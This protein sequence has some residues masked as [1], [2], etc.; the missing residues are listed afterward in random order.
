MGAA[1]SVRIYRVAWITIRLLAQLGYEMLAQAT[2]KHL[3]RECLSSS[4]E[5]LREVP[6][7]LISQGLTANAKR[8]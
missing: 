2:T 4:G 1:V 6:L 5:V 8:M 3:S 7:E